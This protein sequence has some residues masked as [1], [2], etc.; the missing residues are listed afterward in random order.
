MFY[1]F[2]VGGLDT[3]YATIS[4]S[5]R[6]IATRPDFQQFLRDNPDKLNK[7]VDELLRMFSVV[8]TQRRVT[9]DFSFTASR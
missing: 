8:S 4:W 2:Y 7:A 5:M 1:T 3:V 6:Y 9:R